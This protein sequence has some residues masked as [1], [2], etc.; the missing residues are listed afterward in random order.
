MSDKPFFVVSSWPAPSGQALWSG[1]HP[2]LHVEFC[3][4]VLLARGSL[5]TLVLA[6]LQVK[7][8]VA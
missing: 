2:L 5:G 3:S 8:A 7:Q 6:C 4:M 1:Q